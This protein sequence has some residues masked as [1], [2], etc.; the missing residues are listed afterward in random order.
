MA[1]MTGGQALVRSLK[2]QGVDTLFG[3]PGVQMDHFFNALYE[4]RNEIRVIQTRHEQGAAYMAYGYAAA[5]G[6]VGAFAV[7]PGPGLLNTTAALSTAYACNA[8]VLALS[9]QIPSPLIGR[10]TGQLHEIP[11][12]LSLVRGLTKWAERADHPSDAPR[13]MQEAFHQLK[14]GRVRPV[15]IE[16]SMDIMAMAAEVD[17]LDPTAPP[18]PPAPDLDAI[19][20]IAKILG[21]ADRPML[22]AGGGVMDCGDDLIAV[23]ELLDVPIVV[24]RSALGA[25]TSRH[26]LVL[27]LPAGHALWKKADAAA[28]IGT[29]MTPPL[30]GW[31]LDAGIK[32]VRIDIDQ[33]ETTR[34]GRPAASVVAD[35]GA[36]LR[37]LAD[38]LPKYNKKRDGY[39]AEI[40][41]A[42]A[43]FEEKLAKLTPQL[44]ILKVIR[45]ALPDDGIF[46]DELTQVGYVARFGYPTYLP[47]TFI[48]TGYQGTLGYGF[49]T[50][51]GVKVAHPDT[52]VIC[53]S[54][55][56]GFMYNVQELSTAVQ[57]GIDLVTI[58]FADGKFGN[59]R[60]MQI[61]DHGGKVIATD[62]HNPDFVKL[63]EAFGAQGLRANS[64]EE[65]A[66]ALDEGLKTPGP[67]LIEMPMEEVPSPWG[68]IMQGPARP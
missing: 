66:K 11:D 43:D 34:F 32:V 23:A 14:S 38:A 47:R 21:E 9:G 61:E 56:G 31:G 58:V 5:T 17:L 35:A 27:P 54:G 44:D 53:I 62:L 68:M 67:T 18:P 63:A 59:V 28:G 57:H 65:L 55:D 26:P 3:I 39:R 46:V 42:R 4:E 48:S 13:L 60:R 24:S 36:A 25:V 37:A 50:A 49:A 7:V 16:M 19:D 40:D 45:N 64:V 12:Q 1:R 8:P 22:F 10:G 52:P 30:P 6:K 20:A 33:T 51:L 15:E 2:N 41:A 29:R